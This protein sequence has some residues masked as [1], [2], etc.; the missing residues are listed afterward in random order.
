[1]WV[2]CALWVSSAAGFVERGEEGGVL[3]GIDTKKQQ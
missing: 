1:M 3:I 2:G